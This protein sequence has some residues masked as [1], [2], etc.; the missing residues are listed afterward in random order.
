MTKIIVR[1]HDDT[2]DRE[3][4]GV[5]TVE[6]IKHKKVKVT[7]IDP[8]G[9]GITSCTWKIEQILYIEVRDG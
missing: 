1:F 2:P 3:L 6:F 9:N 8:S 4:N 7:H 5:R